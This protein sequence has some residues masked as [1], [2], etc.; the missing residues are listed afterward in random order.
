MSLLRRLRDMPPGASLPVEWVV[1]Q[2][3]GEG[4]VAA[5]EPD[6]APAPEPTW[7]ERL[8]TAPAETRIGREE[9]L[10]AFGRPASWL[11]RHTS[12]KTIPH[13][14]FDGELIFT[15][16]ELRA[17]AR[18]REEVILAGPMESTAASRGAH[19]KAS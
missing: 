2:M 9:V 6:I 19:L 4:S 10:E 16:G 14:K 18:E 17:W 1:A 13:R 5:P 12:G 3:E 8:W 15:V 11:Y 7:R